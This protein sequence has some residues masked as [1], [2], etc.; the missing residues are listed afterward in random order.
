MVLITG[1]ARGIGAGIARCFVAEGA[2][3]VITDLDEQMT[4]SAAAELGENAMGLVA[5]GQSKGD[6]ASHS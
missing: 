4:N 1:A 3:V 6:V 2:N 5:D